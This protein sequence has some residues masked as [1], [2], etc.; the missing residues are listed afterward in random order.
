[1]STFA[2]ILLLNEKCESE[3]NQMNVWNLSVPPSWCEDV[4]KSS[5]EE[6]QGTLEGPLSLLEPLDVLPHQLD[7]DV[8]DT[9]GRFC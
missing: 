1:M 9:M 2:F 4:L 3:P 8:Y 6:T 5:L 7:E